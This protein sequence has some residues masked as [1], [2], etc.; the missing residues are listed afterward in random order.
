MDS[1]PKST[2][3]LRTRGRILRAARHLLEE[4]GYHGV[5]LESVAAAAG[6]SRQSIYVHFGS[7]AN[8]LLALV[9]HVDEEGGLPELADAVQKA[10]SAVEGLHRFVDL[11][12]TLTPRVYRTAAVLDA[13]RL[14]APEAESAWIDR[15][16]SRRRRCGQI[17]SRLAAEGRL[18]PEWPRDEAADFLWAM[19][20]LRVW[21]DLVVRR[22]WSAARFRRHLRRTLEHALLAEDD[23]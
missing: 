1:E 15:M 16:T 4:R 22:G 21:E 3:A 18:A 14:D 5:G 19:T 2:R 10:P 11:V 8:L 6:V 23:A 20:S 12:A 13:A 9:A 7:K 17:A